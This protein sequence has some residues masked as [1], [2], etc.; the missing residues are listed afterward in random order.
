MDDARHTLMR[1]AHCTRARVLKWKAVLESHAW[2]SVFGLPEQLDNRLY[3]SYEDLSP[4]LKQCFL[5]CSLFPEGDETIQVVVTRVWISEGFIQPDLGASSSSTSLHDEYG[6]TNLWWWLMTIDKQD[7]TSLRGSGSSRSMLVRRLSLGRTVSVAEWAVLQRRKSLRTLIINSKVKFKFGD[8][9]GRS[10]SSLRVLYISWS[11]DSD[12]LVASLSK[13][14]HLR[15]LHLKETDVSRIPEDVHRMKLLL[16]IVLVNCE[17][18]GHLPSSITKLAHLRTLAL[19]DGTNINVV[20]R[21][22]GGLSN[23]RSLYGFPVVHVD[24]MDAG[25]GSSSSIWCS[26]QELAPLSQLTDL[27]LNGLE[28]VP[29]CWMAEQAMISSKAHLSYLEL[30]YSNSRSKHTT[31]TEPCGDQ[32]ANKQ[33]QQE[34]FEKLCPPPTCLENLRVVGGYVGFHLPNWIWMCAPASAEF[35]SLRYLELQDLPCCT[36]LPD[37]LRCLPSLECLD[38]RNA[39][40]VKRIGPEFQASLASSASAAYPP[41]PKL[42]VLQLVGLHEWEEWDWNEDD[43]CEGDARAAVI[44]MPCLEILYIENCKLSCLPSGLANS[45][46]HA[47]P[48]ELNLYEITNLASVENFPYSVVDL[49]LSDCP[50]LKRI[51]G[52]ARLHKIRIQ[53]CP[54]LEVLEGVPAL[55]TL[56]LGDTAMEALPGYLQAVNPRYLDLGCSM[57]LHESLSSSGSSEWNK[58][59]H[60]GKHNIT[61]LL[62]D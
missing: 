33:K 37:G 22:F 45:K 48:R 55:D 39:P 43:S 60:I 40:A 19:A 44:A 54:N 28:K 49:D 24:D 47:P 5:Y 58:T 27:T 18:L 59:S 52:L 23:L 42:R 9:L 21:G 34:V 1:H 8:S 15:Y 38:V 46:R 32:E 50:K 61:V 25:T 10:F 51:S 16:R 57:E 26:L 13:L 62:E 4:Q 35:K 36:H 56:M 29:S 53:R 7:S 17:K 2:L 12:R 11:A 41:F 31:T 3:L 20:P 14:K 6:E 30:N